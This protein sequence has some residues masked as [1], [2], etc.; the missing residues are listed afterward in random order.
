MAVCQENPTTI[1]TP[2]R[3]NALCSLALTSTHRDRLE[4]IFTHSSLLSH[5]SKSFSWVDSRTKNEN[6]WLIISGFINDFLKLSWSAFNEFFLHEVLYVISY[7]KV[8][9][10][11][12]KASKNNHFLELILT[13]SLPFTWKL[14]TLWW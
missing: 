3:K 1:F 11:S 6:D 8:N 2:F 7:S 13:F 12:S 10:I 9:S 14:G 4:L 5:F